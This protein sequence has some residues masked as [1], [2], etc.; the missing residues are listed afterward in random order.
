MKLGI[1]ALFEIKYRIWVGYDTDNDWEMLRYN[2]SD[3]VSII[4]LYALSSI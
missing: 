4:I 1:L 3:I 2:A